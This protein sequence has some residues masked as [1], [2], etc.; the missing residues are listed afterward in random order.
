[1]QIFLKKIFEYIFA[2]LS[3]RLWQYWPGLSDAQF[4]Y[5]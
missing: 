2:N 1:M 5:A 4:Q 3:F